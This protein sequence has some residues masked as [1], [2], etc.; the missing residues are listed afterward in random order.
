VPVGWKLNKN[1]LHITHVGIFKLKL[2][3]KLNGI[4]K[5]IKVKRDSRNHWFV[6]FSCDD[7]S[8]LQLPPKKNDA[9]IDMGIKV[10]CFDSDGNSIENK[11]TLRRHEDELAELQRIWDKKK[12]NPRSK[13]KEKAR[14]KISKTHE[15]IAQIRK[16]FLHKISK[17]YIKKYGTIYHENLN[18]RGMIRRPKSKQADDG[19]FLPTGAS[20]KAGLNKSMADVAWGTFFNFLKYKAEEAG[21]KVIE[22]DPKNTSQKCSGCGV[23]VPKTLAVREHACPECG[24]VIDRDYNAS[25]NVLKA[26]RALAGVISCGALETEQG[27]SAPRSIYLKDCCDKIIESGTIEDKEDFPQRKSAKGSKKASSKMVAK[28][29]HNKD[30]P[31]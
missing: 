20:R 1:K 16:D 23:L 18:I 14:L 22:V 28:S 3:R 5:E 12:R 17:K 4:I 31:G 6:S 2:H 27:S 19:R 15:K 13:R 30:S 9:G 24:L 25:I 8:I 10:F 26:G 29:P 11:R 21:R 7:V